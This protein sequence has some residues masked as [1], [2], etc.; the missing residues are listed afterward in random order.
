MSSKPV[1]FA[2]LGYGSDMD[3][4]IVKC[5]T[6]E[7]AKL[8]AA[9]HRNSPYSEVPDMVRSAYSCDIK[10]IIVNSDIEFCSETEQKIITWAENAP[11]L[12]DADLCSD[13]VNVSENSSVDH[14]WL[15]YMT[16]DSFCDQ[17]RGCH[18]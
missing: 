1:F 11:A 7:I 13:V 4:H 14:T 17:G 10:E 9:Y 2:L 12:D 5:A 3:L 6:P 8:V 16:P 18:E 15:L